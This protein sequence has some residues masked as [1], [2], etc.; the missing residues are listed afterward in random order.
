VGI[1]TRYRVTF[2]V[3]VVL[4][5][6]VA[7]PVAAHYGRVDLGVDAISLT[8]ATRTDTGGVKV[9]GAV[10]CSKTTSGVWVGVS[11]RQVVGRTK[12]IRG[13]GGSS[14]RCLAGQKVP[15]SVTVMPRSGKFAGGHALVSAG[16]GKSVYYY[17]RETEREHYHWDSAWTRQEMQLK[18]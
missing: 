14:I 18:R 1:P 3:G 10:T 5:V 13:S 4:A 11:V 9:A 15:Y 8:S 6:L 2:L 16:A 17:D 7:A 12:T